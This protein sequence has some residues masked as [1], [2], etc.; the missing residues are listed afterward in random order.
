M[1]GARVRRYLLMPNDRPNAWNPSQHATC[2]FMVNFAEV[3]HFVLQQVRGER[4]VRVSS[5]SGFLAAPRLLRTH[6][7][8]HLFVQGQ[9]EQSA[10]WLGVMF[11]LVSKNF[12]SRATRYV[13]FRPSRSPTIN[14]NSTLACQSRAR[15]SLG[16]SSRRPAPAHAR[17]HARTH[18]HT[19]ARMRARTRMRTRTRTRTS[20]RECAVGPF[21]QQ[22][23]NFVFL[24]DS[25]AS[26]VC[27]ISF[28]PSFCLWRMWFWRRFQLISGVVRRCRRC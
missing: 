16:G 7:S 11:R 4:G 25:I 15:P 13:R 20:V 12:P 10:V 18:T 19:R 2:R 9:R 1:Q 22:Q 6:A 14:V 26:C 5:R 21:S 27:V 28:A 8:A 23:I 24:I 3:C 17:T